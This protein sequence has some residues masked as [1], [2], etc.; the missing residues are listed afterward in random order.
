ME[1]I[2]CMVIDDEP[3]AAQMVRNFVQRTP[4]L[5]F[6]AMYTDAVEA[7]EALKANPVDLLFLDIHMPDLDGMSLAAMVPQQTRIIFTTAFKE[8]AFDSYGVN[9]L[10]FLLKPISYA[11]FLAAAEKARQWFELTS[12]VKDE[13]VD[14]GRR[15]TIFLRVDGE[16]KQIS[17]NE[18]L[19]VSGLKNY[20]MFYLEGEKRPLVTHLT[21]KTVEDILPAADFMRVHRSYI[22][23][24][25]KIKSI[26]RNNTIQIGD[27]FI[28]V[29]EGYLDA[30]N[31]YLKANLP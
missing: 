29:S 20:V 17:I 11:R 12:S 10:D 3:L 8:Y 31:A 4:F 26:D 16:L 5:E 9:A 23:A 27:E 1:S 30:F 7:L 6:V 2:R 14:E 24:L 15:D 18:I 19:Y 21:M 28:H 25:R 22:V 13:V